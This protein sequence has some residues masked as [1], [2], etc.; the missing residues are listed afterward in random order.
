[1]T[2]AEDFQQLADPAN[3]DCQMLQEWFLAIQLLMGPILSQ[4]W[5]HRKQAPAREDVDNSSARWAQAYC[6][7]KPYDR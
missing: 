7:Y 2:D 3:H 4:E 6:S 1:M 5:V